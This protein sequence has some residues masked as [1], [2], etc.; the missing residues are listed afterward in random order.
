VTIGDVLVMR[1][2]PE[3]LTVLGLATKRR[4]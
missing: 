2:G 3:A 1:R 4:T